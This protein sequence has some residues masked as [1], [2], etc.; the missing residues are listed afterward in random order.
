MIRA[1]DLAKSLSLQ[2]LIKGIGESDISEQDI[3]AAKEVF[4]IGTTLDVLPVTTY[5]GKKI[6]NGQV[7]AVA[8]ALLELV[9]E[10]IKT[11][12]LSVPL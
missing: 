9:R 3:F 2:G 11:G 5:E 12:P 8:K 10:D 7:G 4:M 6:G 1:F